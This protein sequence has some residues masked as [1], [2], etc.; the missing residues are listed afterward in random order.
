MEEEKPEEVEVAVEEIEEEPQEN[1]KSKEEKQ[2]VETRY[3]N[4]VKS[5][6]SFTVDFISN[7]LIHSNGRI[8]ILYV[9]LNKLIVS[10]KNR[11]TWQ[12]QT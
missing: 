9:A 5:F 10:V 4:A 7:H 12:V 6:S 1:D 8:S 11:L 2:P 3:E